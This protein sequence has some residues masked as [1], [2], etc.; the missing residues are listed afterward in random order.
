MWT[1][2]WATRDTRGLFLEVTEFD[3]R[4]INEVI[5]QKNG[6]T[7]RTIPAIL[8]YDGP[9]SFILEWNGLKLA[10]SPLTCPS[11]LYQFLC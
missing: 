11:W 3:Y 5:Y 7:T 8:I 2:G 9:V 10:Y 4:A 1:R 6:V